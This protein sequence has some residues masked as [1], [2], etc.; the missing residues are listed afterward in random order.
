MGQQTIPDGIKF[1]GN[2][3]RLTPVTFG[4]LQK[5]F[6][7]MADSIQDALNSIGEGAV[8][9]DWTPLFN[10]VDLGDDG[11]AF[12]V[13]YKIGDLVYVS[14]GFTLGADSVIDDDVTVELPLSSPGNALISVSA[15]YFDAN[16]GDIYEL[17]VLGNGAT[18]VFAAK[19]VDGK[20]YATLV[21]VN[22][23]T[24]V[25]FD[26]GSSVTFSALYIETVIPNI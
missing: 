14:G 12:G 7:S 3:D 21:P 10:G 26:D 9:L 4:P 15:V 17:S 25:A 22:A 8:L 2:V 6:E 23:T 16:G 13:A 5:I 19:D 11:E 20:N 24:P 1:P 18:G